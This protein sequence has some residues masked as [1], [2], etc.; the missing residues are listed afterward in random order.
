MSTSSAARRALVLMLVLFSSSAWPR[1]A[2]ATDWVFFTATQDVRP[3]LIDKINAET[4]RIDVAAWYLSEHAIS[5]AL[6]NAF[7]R[8]VAVRLIGDRVA[9]FESDPLTRQEYFWLAAQG[10]P[11]RLRYEPTSQPEPIHWKATIFAAQNL[12]TFGSGNYTPFEL[13]PVSATNYKDETVMYSDDPSLVNAF[14]TKFD[15]MWNDTTAEPGSIVTQPPYLKNWNDACRLESA[16]ASYST[17]YPTP[18]PMVINTARLEP[19]YPLPADMVWG[20][21]PEFNQRLV[22]EINRET[23]RVDLVTYRLTEASVADALIAKFRQGVPVRVIIDPEQYMSR[24]WPEYWLTH[25]NIDRLYMAGIQVRQRAHQGL[26]HMKVLITSAYA[27]NASSNI[28]SLWQRDHNLF[29]SAATRPAAYTALRQ[30]FEIMWNDAVGFAPFTPQPADTPVVQSPVN[31]TTPLGRGEPLVWRGMPFATSYDVYFGASPSALSLVASIPAT[32]TMT[33]PATYSWTPTY[34]QSRT[35]YYWRVVSRTLT[36]LSSPSDVWTFTT[37]LWQRGGDFDGDGRSDIS[38]YRPNNG[39]WFSLNTAN[40][41]VGAVQ[42]GWATDL[43]VP[44]DYD[45]D[46]RTDQ[47]VLRPSTYTWYV[48]NSS[49]GTLGQ[50][51]WGLANDV[52]VPADYD[53]DRQADVATWRPSNGTWYIRNSSTGTLSTV[54]W[55]WASDLP[56]V[57][58]F[59]GD[60]RAD[61]TVLRPSTF[62]WYVRNSASGSPTSVQ[63][64]ATGDLPVAADYDG[65]GRT[66]IAVFRPSNGT[67]YIRNSSSGAQTATQWGWATD[68]PVVGDFDGDG[69]ADVS[70]YRPSTGTWYIQYSSTGTFAVQQWGWATD[71]PILKPPF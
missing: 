6:V 55:G 36:G 21:G 60:G 34:V 14:K 33:P 49:T 40:G 30:R 53:G 45:G 61:V 66:D 19:D 56:I 20:Q 10:I 29:V 2:G 46:G 15:R 27:T 58:D 51:Q 12:V 44:A 26:T 54:Q 47:A 4:V 18:R 37:G 39:T 17:L 42:W 70:V 35:R 8:G 65:D 64:G 3:T 71:V 1:T 52:P 7:N 31:D 43:P 62:T 28:A 38:V 48:R 5:I 24:T 11:I 23:V 22:A 57:G 59:D 68:T 69:R 67:W 25:A 9:I 50:L 63:W 13:A 41:G 16:C 32:L